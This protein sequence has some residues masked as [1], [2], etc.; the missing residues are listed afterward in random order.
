M[1][2]NR[3]SGARG[4]GGGGGYTV[5]TKLRNIYDSI[6]QIQIAPKSDYQTF[7]TKIFEKDYIH[8]N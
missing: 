3:Y 8:A 7:G 5:N 1:L 4:G 6:G 2:A